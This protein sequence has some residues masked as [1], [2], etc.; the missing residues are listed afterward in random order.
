[1]TRKH[2]NPM[3]SQQRKPPKRRPAPTGAGAP[4]RPAAPALR[5]AVRSQEGIR[6]WLE[7]LGV[8][9]GPLP[10]IAATAFFAGVGIATAV[11]VGIHSAGKLASPDAPGT[12]AS[13]NQPPPVTPGPPDGF[14]ADEPLAPDEPDFVEELPVEVPDESSPAPPP[15]KE[16]T[17]DA[18]LLPEGPFRDIHARNHALPLPRREFQPSGEGTKSAKLA[19]IFVHSPQACDLTILGDQYVL[20][21]GRRFV[22][23]SEDGDGVRTWNVR[24]TSPGAIGTP[25]SIGAFTLR[26]HSLEFQWNPGAQPGDRPAH[27]AYCLLKLEVDGK[28]ERCRLGNPREIEPPKI[29]WN[30]VPPSAPIDIA[31]ALLPLA[32]NVRVDFTPG[33]FP[34]H[35]LTGNSALKVDGVGRVQIP[36]PQGG[37]GGKPLV[38]MEV[39]L[40]LDE[41]EKP[42]LTCTLVMYPRV[43]GQVTEN[44]ERLT[45]ERFNAIRDTGSRHENVVDRGIRNAATEI[46]KAQKAIAGIDG[47]I[48]RLQRQVG[49][50][51]K[52]K[53]ASKTSETAKVHADFEIAK[54]NNEIK[55]LQEAAQKWHQSQS[56]WQGTKKQ[57]EDLKAFAQASMA[58]Y[59]RVQ[60]ALNQ[61]EKH[62]TMGFVLYVEVEGERVDIL[63]T[64]GH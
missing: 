30:A 56:N 23:D 12:M 49:E 38:E 48:A 40:Q 43:L 54:R 14:A 34:A 3:N 53:N 4:A 17:R 35:E 64:K 50:F 61:L 46:A 15:E 8:E 13:A 11:L 60:A 51:E 25:P 21:G 9:H 41:K 59:E 27:L 31:P 42:R 6:A 39:R 63:R 28:S 33:G 7:K 44:P 45:R 29:D 22:V 36:D 58:W 5:P 62:G 32:E 52:L 19:N 1:M 24:P 18:P 57:N 26:D 2:G 10:L 37:G 16:E 20:D 55:R 47:D